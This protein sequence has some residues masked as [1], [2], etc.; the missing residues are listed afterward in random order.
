MKL[1]CY[2]KMHL[3]HEANEKIRYF[4]EGYCGD[5]LPE[6]SDVV[7]IMSNEVNIFAASGLDVVNSTALVKTPYVQG[8]KNILIT[9]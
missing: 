2:E 1:V 3:A 8:Q 9:N 6:F 5:G 4:R 7:T